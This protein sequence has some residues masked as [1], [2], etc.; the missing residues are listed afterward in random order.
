MSAKLVY[1]IIA[2]VILI[3]VILAAL[4]FTN[5]QP[6]LPQQKCGIENCHGLDLTCGPNVPEAC[7]AIYQLGDR[8]RQYAEC[9]IVEGECTLVTSKAFDSCKA[10]IE[11]CSAKYPEDPV[12]LFQCESNCPA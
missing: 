9:R 1:W 8:C 3:I 11:N 7:T 5:F 12:N 10:C 2:F 6:V 4:T